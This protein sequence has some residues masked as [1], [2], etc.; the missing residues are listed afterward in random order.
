MVQRDG[1]SGHGAP[2]S[3][4]V[5]VHIFACVEEFCPEDFHRPAQHPMLCCLAHHYLSLPLQ[6]DVRRQ[7]SHMPTS[8]SWMKQ[9]NFEQF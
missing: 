1:F 8:L 7:A 6:Q 4:M 9:A 3:A 2:I 5:A